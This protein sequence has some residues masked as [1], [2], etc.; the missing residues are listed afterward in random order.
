MVWKRK[1][2]SFWFSKSR[3]NWSASSSCCS[4]IG[5]GEVDGGREW[6]DKTFLL[7]S[8]CY[9]CSSGRGYSWGGP[10]NNGESIHWKIQGGS[11]SNQNPDCIPW[12][13]G[14]LKKN[15]STCV[16]G[17]NSSCSFISI[18]KIYSRIRTSFVE[19]NCIA[20][21]SHVAHKWSI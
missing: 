18:F 12:F 7:C 4:T 19:G 6:A 20:T 13:L 10:S 17:L 5:R 8:R 14:K 9:I 11:S 16:V 3:I 21:Q 15:V 2:V 1:A